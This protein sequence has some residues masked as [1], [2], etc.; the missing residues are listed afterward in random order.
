MGE[1]SLKV[2]E[3]TMFTGNILQRYSIELHAFGNASGEDVSS[4][5][6]VDNPAPRT[7]V[8]S[9]GCESSWEC[10]EVS[11]G[12]QWLL[13]IVVLQGWLDSTIVV[14]WIKGQGRF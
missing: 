3:H 14:H 5:V 10:P 9:H 13:E 11:K 2:S 7:C 4:A 8:R 12:F 6:Y 1:E